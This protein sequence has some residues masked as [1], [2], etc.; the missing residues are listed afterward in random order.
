[1]RRIV[2]AGPHFFRLISVNLR[3]PTGRGS[4]RK[5]YILLPD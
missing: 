4:R 5:H 3:T 2:G 1:M